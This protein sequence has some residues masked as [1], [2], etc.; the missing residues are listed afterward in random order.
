VITLVDCWLPYGDTEIYVTIDMENHLGTLT[1]E[2]RSREEPIVFEKEIQIALD[3]PIGGPSIHELVK[4][5]CTVSIAVDGTMNTELA[6]EGLKIITTRLVNLIV[7]R[8]RITI[9]LGNGER[10]DHGGKILQAIR[11]NKELSQI[12]LLNNTKNSSN[13]LELGETN[14]GTP[15]QVRREYL[16]ASLK[17][18]IGQT[19]VDPYTGFKGAFSAIIPGIASNKTI[20]G[21]RKNYFKENISPGKIEN[22]PIKED[23]LEIV[24]KAGIDLALNFAVDYDG[25]LFSVQSGGFEESWGKSIND[26]GNSYE[27]KSTESA[28][29]TVVSAGGIS[30]D[31]NLYKALWALE[32]A[33][34]ITKRNGTIILAAECSEGLGAEAFT[35]LSRVRE[36]S[37]FERRYTYGAEVLRNLKKIT[38]VNKVIL[39]STLPI[40]LTDP[41]EIEAA[42]TLNEGYEQAIN[43]RRGRKTLV[44]QY[45]CSTIIQR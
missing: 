42:R 13:H 2:K 26:L 35:K 29:I 10:E 41:L 34:K 24:E 39:E 14:R 8:D 30:Y 17:I 20:E 31:F 9:L 32:N 5:D 37:E 1:P 23:T 28:D 15:I 44:I 12:R 16:D 33:S 21:N 3:E 45:G 22:N 7:P 6:I 19:Q 11:E 38:R 36:L 27:I 43:T 40:Y 4:P 25:T 18:A